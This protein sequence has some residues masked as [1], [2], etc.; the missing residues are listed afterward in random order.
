M[1]IKGLI[2]NLVRRSTGIAE[3]G[4]DGG[5]EGDEGVGEIREMGNAFASSPPHLPHPHHLPTFLI[6]PT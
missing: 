1:P 3:A 4:E 6:L 2:W 5:S